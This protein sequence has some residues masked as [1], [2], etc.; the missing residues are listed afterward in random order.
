M[1][2]FHRTGKSPEISHRRVLPFSVLG[3]CFS[4]LGL[5]ILDGQAV[6]NSDDNQAKVAGS[7][8]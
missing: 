3:H 4:V 6:L 1:E 7:V 2:V 8:K 5:G